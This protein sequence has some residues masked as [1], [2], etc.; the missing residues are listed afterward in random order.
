MVFSISIEQPPNHPL[1]LRV[2]STRLVLEELD[3]ALAQ[4]DRD[5]DPFIPKHE[6]LGTRKEVRNDLEPSERFVRVPDVLAHTFACPCASN[7]RRRF[8]LRLHGT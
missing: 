4:C 6:V 3:A 8:G 7:R 2:V 5:L 1:I